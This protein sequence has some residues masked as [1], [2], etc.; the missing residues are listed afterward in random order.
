M[1]KQDSETDAE[2]R[3]AETASESQF[4][5]KIQPKVLGCR[6]EKFQAVG[7]YSIIR[8]RRVKNVETRIDESPLLCYI[9]YVGNVWRNHAK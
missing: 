5:R 7:I 1:T 2:K 4:F 9:K 3:A 6:G 8:S